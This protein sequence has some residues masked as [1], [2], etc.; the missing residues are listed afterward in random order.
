MHPN[1]IWVGLDTVGKLRKAIQHN[2]SRLKIHPESTGIVETSQRPH[3]GAATPSVGLLAHIMRWS[4]LGAR[5]GVLHAPNPY[6][7]ISS[8]HH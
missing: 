4:P 5:P 6:I 3:S 2:W 7:M 1:S 8:R